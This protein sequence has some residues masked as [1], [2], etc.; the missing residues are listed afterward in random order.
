[1]KTL[2][3][4]VARLEALF[5]KPSTPPQPPPKV[6]AM[7]TVAAMHTT[8]NE[9]ARGWRL[10]VYVRGTRR[11]VAT[12]PDDEDGKRRANEASILLQRWFQDYWPQATGEDA[13]TRAFRMQRDEDAT[14]VSGEGHV[15]DGVL[16]DDG[17]V[18]IRW[19]TKYRSTA[20]YASLS[21]A[22]AIHG[23]D[24]KTRFVFATRPQSP[25]PAAKACE[26]Y[27]CQ[28]CG[29]SWDLSPGM[30]TTCDCVGRPMLRLIKT[31][32]D[33]FSA[34]A[35]KGVSP[36]CADPA[37]PA[38][39][40]EPESDKREPRG[41]ISGSGDKPGETGSPSGDPAAPDVEAMVRVHYYADPNDSPAVYIGDVLLTHG[42]DAWVHEKAGAVRDAL[43]YFIRDALEAAARRARVAA[44]EE[45][46]QECRGARKGFGI[47]GKPDGVEGAAVCVERIDRLRTLAAAEGAG[48]DG[49]R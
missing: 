36:R 23:H 9:K 12:Y 2:E 1:M 26:R 48:K 19:R 24:G 16:F 43:R 5:W 25:E 6:P 39:G 31:S 4:R 47:V 22:E 27:V 37:T 40:T 8:I 7:P 32:K 11:D 14:G 35:T 17:S 29:G 41:A 34:P 3:E 18:C 28:R 30:P 10:S 38:I 21:D 42:S 15:A 44:L 49:E 45:A 13:G 20:V 33:E 46:I